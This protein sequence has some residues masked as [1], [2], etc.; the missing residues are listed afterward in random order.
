MN[1]HRK[2]LYAT[3]AGG[4]LAAFVLVAGIAGP[5]ASEIF[6]VFKS[7]RNVLQ[8][9]SDRDRHHHKRK[10]HRHHHYQGDHDDDEDDEEDRGDR[11]Q[12]TLDPAL[13]ATPPANGLILQGSKPKVQVN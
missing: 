7:E 8:A 9:V 1:K 11:K 12:R 3:A 4:L 5:A 10:H 6:P 13:H 2:F